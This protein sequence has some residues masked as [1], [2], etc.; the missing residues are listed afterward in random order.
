MATLYIET[1][2]GRFSEVHGYGGLSHVELQS[3]FQQCRKLLA[4]ISSET[5]KRD[6][7]IAEKWE[8]HLRK[9]AARLCVRE[10]LDDSDL[11][12]IQFAGELMKKSSLSTNNKNYRNFVLDVA[13]HCNAGFTLVCIITFSQGGVVQMK[14]EERVALLAHIRDIQSS[15]SDTMLDTLANQHQ[16]RE[17]LGM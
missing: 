12:T 16:I 14:E 3:L 10:R 7:K 1:E 15:F 13:R 2:N 6:L 8:P 11:K 4:S 9:N 17:L 5:Q